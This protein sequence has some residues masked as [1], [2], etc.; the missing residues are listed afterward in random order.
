PYTGRFDALGAF[1]EPSQLIGHLRISYD[2][3]PKATLTLTLANLINTCFGGQQ[4][5]FTYLSN[6]NVCSYGNLVSFLN[7]IG[8]MYNP[9]DNVQTFLRYPYEPYFG[10]YNDQTSSL[11]TPFSAYLS[12]QLKL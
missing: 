4:T 3:S 8:N 5:G 7:P 11:N 2:L 6:S 1:R 9:G 12:L 10:T